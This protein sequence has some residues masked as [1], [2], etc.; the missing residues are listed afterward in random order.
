MIHFNPEKQLEQ[1]YEQECLQQR[2][3]HVV[4]GAKESDAAVVMQ[5]ILYR[6][7]YRHTCLHVLQVCHILASLALLLNVTRRYG[8]EIG[9]LM[10]WVI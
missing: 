5:I 7:L 6:L 9:D 3:R 10:K 2:A 4:Q 1:R 8:S